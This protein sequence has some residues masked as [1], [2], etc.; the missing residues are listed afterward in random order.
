MVGKRIREYGIFSAKNAEKVIVICKK[1][2]A[3]M[4][5]DAKR[6]KLEAFK[7]KP[8]TK[9]AQRRLTGP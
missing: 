7:A 1:I 2:D 5:L 9:S 6:Q 8:E 4:S 3:T